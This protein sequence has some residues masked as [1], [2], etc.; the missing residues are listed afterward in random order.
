MR[1]LMD[2]PLFRQ[3]WKF[4]LV[5]GVGF[6]VD[7]VS[8]TLL[9]L[10]PAFAHSPLKA[11]IISAALAIAANW[12]GNRYWTFGPHR[13]S[14]GLM[15]AVE[16]FGVSL[17]GTLVALGCLAF[18]HYV[19]RLDSVLEDNISKNVVG[20]VLG[21][22]IRFVLYRSWVY[23]PRRRNRAAARVQQAAPVE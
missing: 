3:L 22:A 10:T 14:R 9:R 2:R 17:L 23:H 20:L 1:A 8:F 18:S 6:V 11:G 15:E 21:S 4:A 12:L 19:L 7:T 13:S 5:G 16:F